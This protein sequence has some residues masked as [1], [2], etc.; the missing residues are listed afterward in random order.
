MVN[1]KTSSSNLLTLGIKSYPCVILNTFGTLHWTH[2]I[3]GEGKRAVQEVVKHFSPAWKNL[4]L[5]NTI[6]VSSMKISNLR[7]GV[8]IYKTSIWPP[9]FHKKKILLKNL[10]RQEVIKNSFGSCQAVV[11]QL[12]GNRQAVVRLSSGSRQ[13][14]A[15]QSS[16]SRLAVIW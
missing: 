15:R 10:D 2:S 6:Y 9:Q 1:V 4:G 16:G 12:S 13:A 7:D 8:W 3:Y 11:K 14:V 5:I